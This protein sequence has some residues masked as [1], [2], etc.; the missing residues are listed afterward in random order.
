[1]ETNLKIQGMTCGN[2]VKH[3]T[4]A[5]SVLDGVQRVEVDLQ[6]GSARVEHDPAQAP[7]A[8]L[9]SALEEEGYEGQ[10]G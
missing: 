2:C 4:T 8:R 3:V 10:A 7:L 6:S 1:M 9:L 5:L